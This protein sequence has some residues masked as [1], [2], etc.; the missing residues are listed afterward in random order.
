[1]S[2]EKLMITCYT[3]IFIVA[4]RPVVVAWCT[5]MRQK[6]YTHHSD[7]VCLVGNTNN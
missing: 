7:R 4:S 6:L 1:M 3:D 2:M 5:Q